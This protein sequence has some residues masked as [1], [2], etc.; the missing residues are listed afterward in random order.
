MVARFRTLRFKL[1]L[2]YV[3][4]FGFIQ[5]ALWGA[6]DVVRTNYMFARFD[7]NLISSA[8]RIMGLVDASGAD[9][10]QA[11][12]TERMASA[13][14]SYEATGLLLE[15]RR[16]DGEILA[17]SGNLR[18]FRLPFR[19]HDRQ[20]PSDAPTFENVCGRI[21]D[22]LSGPGHPLRMATVFRDTRDAEPYLVQVA[23][24]L[25]PMQQVNRQIR[26]LLFVFMFVS[27]LVAGITSWYVVRRALAPVGMVAE[28]ARAL[29]ATRLDERIP[30]PP[31]GDEISEVIAVINDMLERLESQFKNQ[32]QFVAQV[33]HELR[34]PLA[35]LSGEAQALARRSADQ[36]DCGT[37]IMTV[38]EETRRLLRT[39]ESYLV[40][41]RVRAGERPRIAA[42]VS[43]EEVVLRAIQR[44]APEAAAQ[45]VRVVPR[46][47]ASEEAAE[48]VVAGD[49]DLL[50]S[51]IENLLHNAIRHSPLEGV[52][53][54][55]VQCDPKEASVSVR[56]QGPGIPLEQL[57]QVF[58][59][60]QQVTAGGRRAGSA[61]VG[62]AIA[63]GVAELHGGS[64]SVQ[65]HR[66][67]GAEFTVRL[68][69][70]GES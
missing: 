16:E 61:G 26:Q 3:G 1:T 58:E 33:S 41:T 31:G 17:A 29:S 2:L 4:I 22:T 9:P 39:V 50:S 66:E 11:A 19:A 18:G 12:R 20:N 35:V 6:V 13:L 49:V 8:Q 34:T 46:F 38:R 67:G 10:A 52:V 44:C 57:S 15:I 23:A 70:G 63:K 54:I 40:L 28:K 55:G 59:L 21:A 48:P 32:E 14:G 51:M 24:S 53:T 56:D 42:P 43:L 64:I 60:F 65:N 47:E 69:L 45:S 25:E 30:V 68:P 37:F 27:L 62:L 5:V 7:Q 36:R